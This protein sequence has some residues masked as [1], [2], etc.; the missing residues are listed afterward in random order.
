[1]FIYII[2]R[3]V[4]QMVNYQYWGWLRFFFALITIGIPIKHCRSWD[5]NG[6]CTTTYQLV[7]RI[8]QPSTIW[9]TIY[10]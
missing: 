1:M 3:T 9:L 4:K 6:I 5:Y 7:V 8:S 10:N 2:E